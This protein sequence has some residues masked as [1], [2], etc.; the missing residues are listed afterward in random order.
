[1]SAGKSP[2]NHIIE[3]T[4][5]AFVITSIVTG[6]VVSSVEV[7]VNSIVSSSGNK[8]IRISVANPAST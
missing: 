6:P 3:R 5:S 8:E 2:S 1:L 4:S 7:G